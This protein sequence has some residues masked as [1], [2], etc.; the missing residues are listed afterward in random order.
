MRV[1]TRVDKQG[2]ESD[3]TQTAQPQKATLTTPA[4]I[5]SSPCRPGAT[6][7]HGTPPEIRS[8]SGRVVK[9]PKCV[10]DYEQ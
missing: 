2:T 8:R 9:Q 7:V 4:G 1:H 10:K 3:A 6:T 5:Q